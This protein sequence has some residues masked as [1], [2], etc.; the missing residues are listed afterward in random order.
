MDGPQGPVNYNSELQTAQSCRL[1]IDSQWHHQSYHPFHT[2]GAICSNVSITNINKWNFNKVS[3]KEKRSVNVSV[4]D[5]AQFGEK[6]EL[7]YLI[8]IY[9]AFS[10][11]IKLFSHLHSTWDVIGGNCRYLCVTNSNSAFISS[12]CTAD[13]AQTDHM[14]KYI[15]K[16]KSNEFCLC[17]FNYLVLTGAQCHL[18]TNH[19]D[20]TKYQVDFEILCSIFV[21]LAFCP[22]YQQVQQQLELFNNL[23]IY[24][25]FARVFEH[26][27]L[28]PC[29]V[30]TGRRCS[31]CV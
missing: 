27:Y 14:Q 18:R 11:K 23:V 12:A 22:I 24:I 2:T 19:K 26:T 6:P 10:H 16:C 28:C 20:V 30:V 13:L 21:G 3:F 7:F 15:Y 5:H 29:V 17:I 31:I 1:S 9:S 25:L 4:R 8:W